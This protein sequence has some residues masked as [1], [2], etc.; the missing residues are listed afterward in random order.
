MTQPKVRYRT[1]QDR[2][3]NSVRIKAVQD[4]EGR[5]IE[6]WSVQQLMQVDLS[7]EDDDHHGEP[8]VAYRSASDG[9]GGFQ[10]HLD[11][12]RRGSANKIN[13]NNYRKGTH[14]G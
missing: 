12:P 5:W 9:A 2:R 8:P 4:R 14:R 6:R 11:T 3:G 1:Y 13:S 10:S 7:R